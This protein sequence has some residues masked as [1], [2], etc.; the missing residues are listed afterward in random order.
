MTEINELLPE[1]QPLRSRLLFFAFVL[2]I[3][4]GFIGLDV[5]IASCFTNPGP[6]IFMM[7]LV[8]GQLTLICVWGT[9]VEG[10]FWFRLPWTI[11]LLVISWSALCY[12]LYL[13]QGYVMSAEI[14]GMG[15]VWLYGFVISY[16]PLKIAAWL[17]GWR[18]SF[19]SEHQSASDSGRY[20]IRDIMLGTTILAVTLAIG[21]QFMPSEL[22]QWSDVL[23]ASGL[24]KSDM[25]I[26]FLLFSIISLF[27]KLP[28]IWIA[29]ASLNSKVLLRSLI[30][31]VCSAAL[32]LLEMGLLMVIV[33]GTGPDTGEVLISLTLGHSAMAAMMIAVLYVLR[34][35]GYRM[36][37]RKKT[38]SPEFAS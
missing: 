18:I 16:V 17:F 7:I 38:A 30:W 8:V 36:T 12:G 19:V 26:A 3:F 24:D 29:L 34:C 32:G 2:L 20:A 25:L 1:S 4:T 23:R 15:L 13:D 6:A 11:L 28:C 31:I 10:T 33:G 9:L 5:L 21:R 14:M 35:F 27:V 22:P 37:R